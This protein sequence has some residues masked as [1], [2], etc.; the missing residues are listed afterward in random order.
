MGG[1]LV[2]PHFQT[3]PVTLTDVKISTFVWGFTMGFAILTT[4]KAVS[5]TIS[6][7]RRTNRVTVAYI[8]MVW[9]ELLVNV[10]AGVL[11]WVY[12]DGIIGPRYVA[13]Y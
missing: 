2:P 7:W 6:I 9:L 12:M 8:W 10:I 11:S 3:I 4:W 5:Q 13:L 1:F